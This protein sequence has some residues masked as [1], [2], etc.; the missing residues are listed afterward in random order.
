MT[1]LGSTG[2]VLVFETILN[3]FSKDHGIDYMGFRAW[4][5]LWT[6]F[7]LIIIVV[8]D[9][10]ALVKYI[11]RFTGKSLLIQTSLSKLDIMIFF[12]HVKE[13]SF[14]ALIAFIFI[15]ESIFKLIDIRKKKVYSNDPLNY[16]Q[17]Y[18]NN[19]NCF[20]CVRVSLNSSN[21]SY[22]AGDDLNLSEYNRTACASLG[23]GYQFVKNCKYSPD[24]FYVSVFLY[25]LTF[26]LAMTLRYFRTSR[27]FPTFVSYP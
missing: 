12:Y 6:C 1:I 10:S 4:V 17:E 2:P 8:T 5:G 9:C 7:I 25:A 24:V 23:A 27:F 13:E 3:S 16:Y 22:E 26:F 18:V 11:T 15:K 19:P 21:S 14:A 20:K